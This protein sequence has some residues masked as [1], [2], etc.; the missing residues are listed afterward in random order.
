MLGSRPAD[1]TGLQ[2]IHPAP[3]HEPALGGCKPDS[4]ES[5]GSMTLPAPRG[6]LDSQK[7]DAR[8]TSSTE[9]V[10]VP[11][12]PSLSPTAGQAEGR[13]A[14]RTRAAGNQGHPLW[15]KTKH[16]LP[17]NPAPSTPGPKPR[18]R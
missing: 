2:G 14:G 5:E 4:L 3:A 13:Q 9:C 12:D 16:E 17:L 8:G 6:E 11:L 18:L 1:M 15:E 10:A 7:R